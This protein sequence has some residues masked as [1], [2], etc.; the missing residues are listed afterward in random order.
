MKPNEIKFLL[1]I[2][3]LTAQ[4]SKAVRAKVGGVVTDANGN[5]VAYGYN[6]SINGSNEPLEHKIYARNEVTWKSAAYDKNKY[7]YHDDTF[8]GRDNYRLVTN[9]NIVIHAEWNLV[10]HAARRGI[11]IDGGTVALTL[12]PCTKCTS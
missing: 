6:G 8:D 11:S 7:P 3:S 9:E 2:A 4:R 10:A 12:S 5:M 1:D